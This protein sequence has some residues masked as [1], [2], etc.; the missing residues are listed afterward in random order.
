MPRERRIPEEAKA[1]G[2]AQDTLTWERWCGRERYE[3]ACIRHEPGLPEVCMK[4]RKG[5]SQASRLDG[6]HDRSR[7]TEEPCERKRTCTVLKPR[8]RGRPRCLR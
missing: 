8:Q 2:N 5:I 6:T 3:E 4:C 1:W 7:T